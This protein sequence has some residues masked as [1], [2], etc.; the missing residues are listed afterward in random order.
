MQTMRFKLKLILA[1][2][3]IVLVSSSCSQFIRYDDAV[4]IKPDSAKKY[5]AYYNEDSSVVLRNG[6]TLRGT[7]IKIQKIT[8]PDT[9]PNLMEEYAHKY[10]LYFLDTL[11][12][13]TDRPEIIPLEDVELI[14][15]KAGLDINWFETYNYPL[16]PKRIREVPVDSIFV[17]TCGDIVDCGCREF[18]IPGIDVDISCPKCTYSWYFLELR[19]GYAIYNDDITTLEN[20]GREAY[21]GEAA[22]GGRFGKWGLGLAFNTGVPLYD[23]EKEIDQQRPL[24]LL[25]GR[26]EFKPFA[27]MRPFI[28]GQLGLAIDDLT[29]NLMKINVSDGCRDKVDVGLPNVDLSFPVSYGFGIGLDIPMPACWFDLSF[30]IGFR[31][32]AFGESIN[33]LGYTNVPT[34]RRVNMFVARLGITL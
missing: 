3:I 31:S 13:N 20:I 33:V 21:F 28:Y 26:R 5:S 32:I 24:V 15:P 10:Y 29:M 7:V 6:N 19:A 9:C 8:M 16:Q 4:R 14:G 2:I 12:D 27:C 34:N 23:S 30:D 1:A 11:E 17:D 22:F 25:H 18:G